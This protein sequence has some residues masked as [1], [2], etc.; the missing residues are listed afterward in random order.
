MLWDAEDDADVTFVIKT[1]A[2]ARLIRTGVVEGWRF[3]REG[4]V[5]LGLEIER[6]LCTFLVESTLTSPLALLTL[7]QRSDE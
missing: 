7:I 4:W 5:G 2:Y 6:V 3:L 1:K